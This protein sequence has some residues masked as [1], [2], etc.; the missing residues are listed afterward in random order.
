MK[1]DAGVS[2][3]VLADRQDRDAPSIV[4]DD[5]VPARFVH[6]QIDWTAPDGGLLIERGE[7]AGGPVEGEGAD[8]PTVLARERPDLVRRIQ[9]IAGRVNGKVTGTGSFSRQFRSGQRARR[10]VEA[11][12]IYALALLARV[13]TEVHE[14]VA[15][16]QRPAAL[17]RGRDREKGK[18]RDDQK[19][20][21][22]HVDFLY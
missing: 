13:G 22:T 10:H 20:N 17:T 8:R 6:D 14:Q 11:G 16:R 9:E 7:P 1:A 18:P 19:S 4:R 21:S 3:A 5:H 2:L 15:A 12:D